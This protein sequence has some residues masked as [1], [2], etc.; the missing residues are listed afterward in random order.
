[1]T[2]DQIEVA[3]DHCMDALNVALEAQD[4]LVAYFVEMA[5][6]VILDRVKDATAAQ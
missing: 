4:Q 5:I 3:Y 2:I 1:M 6:L